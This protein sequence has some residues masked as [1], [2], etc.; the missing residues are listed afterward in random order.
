MA[1]YITHIDVSLDK[2]DEQN[3]QSQG[4][5][6]IDV[7]LNKGA[8]GNFIYIWYKYGPVPIT[9]LQI[10][11][12]KE[13]AVG[14]VNAGYTKIDKDLNA[15]AGGDFI[16]LWYLRGSD[17][18]YHTP[19][20]ELT[21]T[22]DA[23]SGARNFSHGWER[24]AGDLNRRAKGEWIHLWVKREKQ[25][26]IHEVTATDSFGSDVD[27]F[28]S[29][30][31][32]LDEDTNRDARGAYVFIWYQPTTEAKEALT[33]LNISTNDEE[34]QELQQQKYNPVSVN[35]NEGTNG[36]PVYLWYKQDEVNKPVQA[37]NLLVNQGA[38]EPYIKAGVT[39]IE[40]N[41][42][43]GNGGHTEFLCFCRKA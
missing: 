22:T 27:L 40:R 11:F 13:M 42:N 4:F 41:L 18:K 28:K 32:R 3:L 31:I 36:P 8:G 37:I 6:K 9:R 7:D 10:T 29:G 34:Y 24:L 38:V 35:L 33:D 5:E 15:G 30:F 26:Y 43:T 2:T 39:V 25:T 17:R 20:V 14:L 21:V 23:E 1:K 16:Y 19:I 12:N